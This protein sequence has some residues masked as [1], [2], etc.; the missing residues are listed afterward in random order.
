MEHKGY[1][2]HWIDIP[3]SVETNA[4]HLAFRYKN[5]KDSKVPFGEL[6]KFLFTLF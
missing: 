4:T 2:S 5:P 1:D 6:N 3:G